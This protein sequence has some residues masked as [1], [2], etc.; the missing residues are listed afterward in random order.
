M[1]SRIFFIGVISFL[2][3][4]IL[5]I[6][7]MSFSADQYYTM[8]DLSFSLEW[9]REF[10]TDPKWLNSMWNSLL[11]GSMSMSLS[12]V[13]GI[14]AALWIHDNKKYQNILIGIILLPII[15]PPLISAVSWYFALSF[16]GWNN[17]LINMIITHFMLGVPFVVICVLTALEKCKTEIEQMAF[18]CGANKYQVF[19]NIQLPIILPGILAGALLAFMTSFD[20][21]IVSLFL[22]SYE[23]RTIPLEMWSGLRENISPVILVV[24]TITTIFSLITMIMVTLVDDRYSS[25]H[26]TKT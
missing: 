12:L 10:A 15:I 17:N 7:I 24:T 1:L 9:Y 21:L 6:V 3:L 11:V 20:E 23:T 13:V 26:N 4:P 22:S 16:I 2:I 14:P 18:I 5:V 8:N 25:S 19:V